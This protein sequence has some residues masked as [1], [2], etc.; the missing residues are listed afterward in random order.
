MHVFLI[1]IGVFFLWYLPGVIVSACTDIVVYG[2]LTA[3]DLRRNLIFGLS[4][5]GIALLGLFVMLGELLLAPG[6]STIYSRKKGR[7]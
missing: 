2:E 7:G 6:E 3:A 5:W 4:G 1:V